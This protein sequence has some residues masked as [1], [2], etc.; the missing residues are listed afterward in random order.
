MREKNITD[1]KGMFAILMHEQRISKSSIL[2]GQSKEDSYSQVEMQ[3]VVIT[4]V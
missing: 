2:Q 1:I 3:I 4:I